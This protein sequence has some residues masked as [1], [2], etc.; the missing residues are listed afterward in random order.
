MEGGLSGPPFPFWGA[1]M[2][3]S[4]LLDFIPEARRKVIYAE[5]DGKTFIVTQQDC[6]AIIEY[7]KAKTEQGSH[8]DHNG[9]KWDYLGEFPDYAQEK[10]IR[11][12]WY[13]DKQRVRRWLTDRDTRAFS[14]GRSS[15]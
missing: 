10:A 12:G 8:V 7:A 9:V 13:H 1:Y 3:K 2:S 4:A 5:E 14:G 6:T 11:E 15:F